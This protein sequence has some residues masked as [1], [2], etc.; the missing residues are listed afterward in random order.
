MLYGI[1]ANVYVAARKTEDIAWINALSYRAV[2]LNQLD[3]YMDN[4][5]FVFNT[6]PSLIL[7]K[8]RLERLHRKALVIDLASKPGGVDFKWAEE[9]GINTIHA[10][11]LPGKVAP[12]TAA[13]IIK[14]TIYNILE[15]RGI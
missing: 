7:N 1:G 4:M 6:V 5:D 11:G 13:R 15:E 12:V 8:E 10:L 2:R 9:L 3:E 14:D